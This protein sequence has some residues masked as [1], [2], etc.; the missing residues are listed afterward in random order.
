MF[1]KIDKHTT[2]QDTILD[3]LYMLV[4]KRVGCS[5]ELKLLK[6]LFSSCTEFYEFVIN[7]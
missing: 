6:K 3:E 2:T 4:K 1:G 7:F 5:Y